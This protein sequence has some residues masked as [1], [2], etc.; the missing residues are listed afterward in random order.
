MGRGLEDADQ[1]T[2]QRIADGLAA[3]GFQARTLVEQVV[4]STPFRRVELIAEEPV[5]RSAAEE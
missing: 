3:E 5:R 4:L 2:V 1:C